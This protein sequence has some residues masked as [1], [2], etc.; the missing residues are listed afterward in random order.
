MEYIMKFVRNE[1]F[2]FIEES[3]EF[4]RIVSCTSLK[5]Y[6]NDK[7]CCCDCALKIV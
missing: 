4:E 7:I 1:E 3:Y 2:D 5:N 6:W